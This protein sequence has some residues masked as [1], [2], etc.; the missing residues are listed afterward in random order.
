MTRF[1]NHDFDHKP[2]NKS[3]E[4]DLHI[5]PKP[6]KS[7]SLKDERFNRLTLTCAISLYHVDDVAS[8]LQKYE[9]VTNQLACIVRCFLELD[10]L[11]VMYCAGAL[12][13]LHLVEP[14]LSLTTSAD[15]TYTKIIPAFQQLYEELMAVDAAT[16][17]NVDQPALKFVSTERFQHTRNDEDICKAIVKVATAFQP[18]VTKLLKMI[19]PKLAAGFQKQKGDIFGFSDFDESARSSV[20]NMDLQKM[21]K[22]PIHNLAAE[23]SVGFVNYELSRRGAKQLGSA[24]ASQVKAKSTDLIDRREPGSFRSYG[25]VVRKGGRMPEIILAW[26]R[27]QEELKKQGLQDKEIV[28]VAVDR[29][30]N[31]DLDALKGLGG[32]FTAAAAVDEYI[33]ASDIEGIKLGRLYLEVRYARDTSLSL[34]KTSDLFSLMKDHTK[35]PINTYAVNLKM[36]LS[37]ITSS[38]QVTLDDFTEAMDRILDQ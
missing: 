12:I 28:N 16:F 27:K 6:N 26:N 31:K 15:T 11:K 17:L 34:P 13:G 19:L 8:F 1:I 23:R 21:D 7:V 5:A 35:L 9:H 38:A 37:N 36:Y 2:W 20:A 4:F 25:S 14:Y 29:R 3:N 32:P 18:Q 30:R 22:A 10:F 24:S 33:A